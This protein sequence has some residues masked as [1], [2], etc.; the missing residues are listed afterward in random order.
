MPPLRLA[1]SVAAPR[2]HRITRDGHLAGRPVWPAGLMSGFVELLLVLPTA[3]VPVQVNRGAL[4]RVETW[5]VLGGSV[6][7]RFRVE[8]RPHHGWVVCDDVVGRVVDPARTTDEGV[9][10]YDEDIVL[11]ATYR[12][13]GEAEAVADELGLRM[14]G[15]LRVCV[16][17]GPAY[18]LWP[19][20][21]EGPPAP[22]L[23]PV[24]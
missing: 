18:Y 24:G 14:G 6:E 12:N 8:H 3:L 5:L 13:R 1:P 19:D 9:A 4:G 22:A 20:E 21:V 23:R 17:V 10:A 7:P 11:G 16:D 15:R 2:A